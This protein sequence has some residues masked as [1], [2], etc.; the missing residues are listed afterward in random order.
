MIDVI[1][2]LGSNLGNRIENIE[3]AINYLN[4]YLI[5]K[6]VSSVYISQS[7]LKDNQDDYYN[8]VCLYETDCSITELL[9]IVQDIENKMGRDKTT[10]FWGARNIDID[11]VDYDN[12]SYFSEKIITPHKEMQNRSFVLYP[13]LEISN[14]Y[15]HPIT[16]KSVKD[17]IN[18]LSDD[19]NIHKINY[20]FS[21][22]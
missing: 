13:L 5:F 17:M 12:I 2:A 21:C 3:T 15:I 8:C 14:N 16:K 11:I 22:K 20:K 7:L 6:K 1:L 4:N 19:L 9:T 18:E 10:G